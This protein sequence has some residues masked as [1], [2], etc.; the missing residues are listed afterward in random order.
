M[1]MRYFWISDQKTSR[2]FLVE[3]KS[4]QENI[5]EYFTKHHY[6][7][8][9][10]RVLPIYHHT[11]KTTQK[12]LLVSL[13]PSMRGCVDPEDYNMEELRKTSPIL[14]ISRLRGARKMTKDRRTTE[15]CKG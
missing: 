13:N 14:L 11:Y 7:R 1:N 8:H 3:W 6:V 9:H 2:D 10:K 15:R 4:G 5:A 12:F